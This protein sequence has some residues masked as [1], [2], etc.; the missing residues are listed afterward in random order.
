MTGDD[1]FACQWLRDAAAELALGILPARE[2]AVAL[3]HL[4]R[5]PACREDV[6]ELTSTAD[7]LIH[8]IPGREPPVGFETRVLQRIGIPPPHRRRTRHR[9]FALAFAACGAA[10][11]LTAGGWAIG[12]TSVPSPSATAPDRLV[13]AELTSHGRDVGQVVAHTDGPRWIY[14]SVDADDLPARARTTLHA[15]LT[16]QIVR[17]DGSTT[18][19]GTFSPASGYARWGAPY[20]DG[21]APVT[22][23][24][25]LAADHSVVAGAT[26]RPSG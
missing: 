6:R 20:P 10:A 14:M 24:R 19:V 2:R 8:L 21:S 26:L 5:C 7:E 25:L 11:A 15:T 16:C 13:S 22:K 18:T 23:V 9:R 12:V 1:V 17:A 3:A 4:Q